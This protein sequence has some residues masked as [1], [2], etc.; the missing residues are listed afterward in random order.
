MSAKE[1]IEGAVDRLRASASVKSVY[2]DPITVDGKTVIPVAKVAYGFGA[3]HGSGTHQKKTANGKTPVEG[4]GEGAGGGVAAR[5]V[6]VV[7]ITGQ[8]TKFVQFGAPKKLMITALVGAGLGVG[9]GLLLGRK[10]SK[11]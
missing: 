11:N 6:G 5:P 8:E 3:G 1:L 9:L 10:S 4:E 7:E 2:G